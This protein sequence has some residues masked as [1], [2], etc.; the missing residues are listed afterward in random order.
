MRAILNVL[1]AGWFIGLIG[2]VLLAVLIWFV[3][4]LLA[5]GSFRPFDGVVAR[6]VTIAVLFLIWAAVVLIGWLRRRRTNAQMAEDLVRA[7][8]ETGGPDTAAS[9][10]AEEVADIKE[11]MQEAMALLKQANLGGAGGG[12]QYLYQ[13]P[14][15]IMIGPPG[16]GK[17]TALLH[18][19]LNFPLADRLRGES[20]E[21]RG[22]GG[23]RN[24]DWVF[25]NEAV[26]I[27][28][29]GRYTTQD[30]HQAV[31]QAA[32][33][34]FLGLLKKYR[35]RQPINGALIAVSLADLMVWSEA[36]R[37]QHARTIKQRIRELNEQL[38]VRFPVYVLF[39]KCDLIAGF[40]EYY[41][42]LGRE[43][44]RQVWGMTFPVDEGKGQEGVVSQFGSEFDL[45]VRR[46]NDRLVE[47][48]HQ[49]QDSVRRSLIYGFPQQIVSLREPLQDFL[50]EIFRPSRFEQRPLLRGV[51]FTSGTQYGTPIDRL[52][53]AMAGTFGIGQQALT[54][55][56]GGGR[57]YFLTRLLRNV[58]FPE[59]GVVS[60]NRREE[61]RRKWIQRA[62]YAT[63]VLLVAGL[64][65]AW[66][67]SYANNRDLIAEAEEHVRTYE[68]QVAGL[69]LNP[70]DST[71]LVEVLPPLN[72]LRT[73]PAGYAA[74]E[75]GVPLSYTFG[76]YQ[77]ERLSAQAVQAY[78]RAL[79]D[80]LLPRLLL[81]LE[82]TIL[83]IVARGGDAETQAER[84]YDPLR[85]Y[86]MMGGRGTM[87]RDFVLDWVRRDWENNLHPGPGNAENRAALQRHLQ[88]LLERPL[89]PPELHGDL[90][91]R[92]QA[93]LGEQPASAQA[94][95]RIVGAPEA[96]RLRDWRV[97]D[98]GGP[99]VRDVI[100]HRQGPDEPLTVEGLYTRDA[101]YTYFIPAMVREAHRVAEER[102]IIEGAEEGLD[103]RDLAVLEDQVLRRYLVDYVD[104]WNTLLRDI[105]IVDFENN[106][107][108]AAQ[109]MT[110]LGSPDSP[111][112]LVLRAVCRETRLSDPPPALAQTG[113]DAVADAVGSGNLGAGAEMVGLFAEY[114]FRRRLSSRQAY[115]YD[116]IREG[117]TGTGTGTDTGTDGGTGSGT[118]TGEEPPPLGA[119][120]EARF[121]EVH[122]Y[123]G[124]IDDTGAPPPIDELVSE[125]QQIA[126][127]LPR[128]S[129]GSTGPDQV[130][131]LRDLESQA[132][133][134]PPAVGGIVTEVAQQAQAAVESGAGGRLAEVWRSDVQDLCLRATRNRYP[135][136]RGSQN[137]VS[138]DDFARLFA[139]GGEIDRYFEEHLRPYVDTSLRQWQFRPDAGNLGLP[140]YVLGQ[141]QNAAEIRDAFWPAGGG[142]RPRIS[143]ELRPVSLGASAN[144]VTLDIDGQVVEYA[145]GP[146]RTYNLEWPGMQNRARVAFS[147]QGGAS[148][149]T[150]QGTW[151]WFRLLD[152]ASRSGGASDRF[153]VTFAVGGM[154]ASFELR[155][156][157]V[158]NPFNLPALG[159]FRCPTL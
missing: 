6:I 158:T 108:R 4:P 15:Y 63:S 9:A 30:S 54:A 133:V 31:D 76:L 52:M 150:K 67:V 62:A 87:D 53:G 61:K 124:C 35:R 84:L 127:D 75:Q 50:N 94:Y 57:S 74:R 103:D 149:R 157:S 132:T 12:R 83:D 92:A 24:C 82:E 20:L 21:V 59:A 70:V 153:T 34:G 113:A 23:T 73:M 5:I 16:S 129:G 17:T 111:L 152:E 8:E 58:V 123:A 147:P 81:R 100:V 64:G 114:Q 36:E 37:Q 138:L 28:T 44:R 121:R 79:N 112:R 25:T 142:G 141:F 72:T 96:A 32:W 154:T 3:G 91:R 119:Y 7:A 135:F 85:A 146:Q 48:L 98:H 46:L 55:A 109:I 65:L 104:R 29:A 117:V 88:A 43:E 39:T 145:H 14:W 137:D 68:S 156:G 125:F 95:A 115:G 101:F 27:D 45:L 106:P 66:Y 2:V 118:G 116:T 105:A 155:A 131:A 69:D 33:T 42:D 26:L 122:L 77:G 89:E 19:G 120:V 86:L 140:T 107:D 136:S 151:A 78:R 134:M 110:Y 148:S 159:A 18:S 97:I 90:V 71:D 1:K 128:G 13:L 130:A 51:Y 38:G 93:I 102:R 139:P 49:E 41:D 143:F 47:R 56:S 40:V 99:F 144:R 80:I 22:V 126:R 10:T 60:V 11:R